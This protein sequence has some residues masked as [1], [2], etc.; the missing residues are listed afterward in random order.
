VACQAEIA[1]APLKT[2]NAT[3]RLDLFRH[4]VQNAYEHTEYSPRFLA[5][6][7]KKFFGAP[8]AP[9]FWKRPYEF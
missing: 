9:S 6:P 2:R 1:G 4:I 7:A 5:E 3:A 8:S